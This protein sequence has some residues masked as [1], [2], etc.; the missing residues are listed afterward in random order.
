M[1]IMT[2]T[3]K[4][5][6]F[7][8]IGIVLVL[9]GCIGLVSILFQDNTFHIHKTDEFDYHSIQYDGVHYTYNTGMIH[10]LFMGIDSSEDK[11]GQAD[12]MQLYTLDRKKKEISV[13]SMDRDT[14]TPIHLYDV[15]H[16]SLGWK[17]QHL[18]LAYAY[19]RDSKNGALLTCKAVS[20]MLYGIPINKYV[21]VN[22][23]DLD[24]IQEIVGTLE[25][26][27][28]NDSLEEV[29]P[30]WTKGTTIT[31]DK[32]NV[33]TFVRS[34]NTNE[35][36]SNEDRMERQKVYLNAYH[37]KLKEILNTDYENT[38][39]KVCDLIKD[40]TCNVTY[41]EVESYVRMFQTFSYDEDSSYY[42]LPGKNRISEMHDEFIL[43]KKSLKQ[44]VVHQYYKK[45]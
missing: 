33:E 28:P 42:D 1:I 37:A 32:T 13:L 34:R 5:N 9:V 16:N 40:V 17:K 7:L 29:N 44:L 41:E 20:K 39:K 23:D 2:T 31:L 12:A 25:V 38:L 19:G 27:I 26:E 30:L 18:A 21:A 45:V 22:L 36:F 11:M 3:K 15:S 4:K 43:D 24:K 14:M 35:D 8:F 6:N 10:I